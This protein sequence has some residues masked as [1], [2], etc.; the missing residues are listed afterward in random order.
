MKYLLANWKANCPEAV[1]WLQE[2]VMPVVQSLTNNVEIII[3]APFT[4]LGELKKA[5]TTLDKNDFLHVAAQDVSRFPNG[6]YTGEVVAEMLRG[7]VEYVLIGHSERRKYFGETEEI[8]A[9]KTKLVLRAGLKPVVCVADEK[10]AYNGYNN[11]KSYNHY[12]KLIFLYEPIGAVGTGQTETPEKV[13]AMVNKIK[14][15]CPGAKVLYGGSVNAD[16]V[17][18][19]WEKTEIDGVGVGKASIDPQEFSKIVE[20]IFNGS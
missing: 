14:H 3:A 8:I 7:L 19:F 10:Q 6:A 17:L 13:A 20:K 11:Y 18:G 9:E 1:K 16:N 5:I 15:L 2:A 4:V 12:N